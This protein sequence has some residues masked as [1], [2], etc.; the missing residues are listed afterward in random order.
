MKLLIILL[1]SLF[2][3]IKDDSSYSIKD[4][5]DYLQEKGYWDIIYNV[6]ISFCDDIAIDVC[7]ALTHSRDCEEVVRIY[8][9]PSPKKCPTNPLNKIK[10]ILV[11][12][13]PLVMNNFTDITLIHTINKC[14]PIF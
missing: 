2:L 9:T 14:C 6:K 1:F 12:A 8:M 4:F 11:K 3:T 5:L 7:I 10:R 13:G